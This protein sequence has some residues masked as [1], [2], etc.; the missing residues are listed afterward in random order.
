M[1]TVRLKMIG[2]KKLTNMTSTTVHSQISDRLRNL[3]KFW[4]KNIRKVTKTDQIEAVRFLNVPYQE[5]YSD[6]D[7]DDYFNFYDDG[8]YDDYDTDSGA[9]TPETISVSA[10]AAT[11]TAASTEAM[12]AGTTTNTISGTAAITTAETTG[13]T[14]ASN[15]KKRRKKRAS[16]DFDLY[17]EIDEIQ[18]SQFGN[19]TVGKMLGTNGWQIS[20]STVMYLAF[21]HKIIDIKK[22]K[23]VITPHGNCIQWKQPFK[24]ATAGSGNGLSVIV[25]TMQDYYTDQFADSTKKPKNMAE[26]NGEAGV[27]VFISGQNEK[28]PQFSSG[29]SVPTGYK[30]NIAL[31]EVQYKLM[32][33]PWGMCDVDTLN[34]TGWFYRKCH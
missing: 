18:L 6:Y 20:K 21:R 10:E 14:T 1:T 8:D 15:S 28:T 2:R 23:S 32:Y 13:P 30:A 24:Q 33:Q 27:K 12:T 34:A 5:H 19:V 7:D 26:L 9:A 17:G 16:Q 31:N 3:V 29:I 22:L 4:P 25:N 11:V